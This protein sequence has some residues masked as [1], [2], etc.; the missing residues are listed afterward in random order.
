MTRKNMG[1]IKKVH[2][3]IIKVQYYNFEYT[4]VSKWIIRNGVSIYI[5]AGSIC[6]HF[7]I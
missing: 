4:V 5:N 2:K 3:E 7:K 6:H 1:F